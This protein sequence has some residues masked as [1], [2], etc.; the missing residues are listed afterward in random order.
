MQIE[1]YG[2][3]HNVWTKQVM[4]QLKILTRGWT[5]GPRVHIVQK[6]EWAR[7]EQGYEKGCYMKNGVAHIRRMP[8]IRLI[9]ENKKDEKIIKAFSKKGIT[10]EGLHIACLSPKRYKVTVWIPG[11]SNC[12]KFV[13]VI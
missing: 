6:F 10:V 8:S 5:V 13:R 2:I 1:V 4:D 11:L 3:A 12:T 7:D 9:C